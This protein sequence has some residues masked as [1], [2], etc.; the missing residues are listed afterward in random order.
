MAN[1]RGAGYFQRQGTQPYRPATG[2]EQQRGDPYGFAPGVS[3]QLQRPLIQNELG[4]SGSPALQQNIPVSW[5]SQ[6]FNGLA[7]EVI[8]SAQPNRVIL[9]IQNISQTYAVAVNYDQ[10]ASLSGTS[11]NWVSQG[12][13]LIPATQ[14]FI[15]KWAPTGTIH[16]AGVNGI[17]TVTQAYSAIG[18]VPFIET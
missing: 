10:T 13:L 3:A 15:D 14:I 6:T 5:I 17:V 2:I 1:R 18:N 4:G 9:L 16:I 11:P 12:V 7:T 8:I